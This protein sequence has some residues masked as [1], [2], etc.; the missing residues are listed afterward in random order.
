MALGTLNCNF[1]L[2]VLKEKPM[3]R[4][5]S[6]LIPVLATCTVL[7]APAP[8]P[9]KSGWDKPIDPGRDC[10]FVIKGGTLTIVLPGTDHDLAPKRER[11]NAPRLLRD[12]E[13]DFMIQVR[14]SASYR[15]SAKSSVDEEEPSVAA[16]LVLLPADGNC[17]RFEYG[18]YRRGGAQRACP[19]FR[20]RGEGIWNMEQDWTPA[21]KKDGRAAEIE[22]IYLG[23]ER[24]GHTIYPFL[25][26][27]GKKWDRNFNVELP[28]LPAK[29][30]VGLAAYSTSTEPFQSTFDQF[31]LIRGSK[32]SQ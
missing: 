21:W 22:H 25:S 26:P 32:K 6:A 12:V 31:K 13:G 8:E 5:I 28:A 17:I 24:Q 3:I 7:A 23:L 14:V 2:T 30:K 9:F 1:A 18:A 11:F 19:A 27:D 20:M 15:P 4:L 10:R 29:L 16:G